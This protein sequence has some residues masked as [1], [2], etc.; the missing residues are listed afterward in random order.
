MELKSAMSLDLGGDHVERRDS[1]SSRRRTRS[2]TSAAKRSSVSGQ[3][4]TLA[5]TYWQSVSLHC[6]KSSPGSPNRRRRA[7]LIETVS[8]T[9]PQ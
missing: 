5:S 3:G 9:V 2:S 7:S 4:G 1:D 6:T 8:E